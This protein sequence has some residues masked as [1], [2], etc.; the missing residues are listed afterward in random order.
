MGLSVIARDVSEQKR[1]EQALRRMSRYFA[2]SRDMVCTAGLD[3]Y[4]KQLNGMWT[5]TLGW[6]DAELRSRP[7]LTFVHPDD[8]QATL[9]ERAMLFDRGTTAAFVNRYA[10]KDGGWRWI[11]WNT[12]YAE[13]EQLIYAT[14]RDVTERRDA[15]SKSRFQPTCWTRWAKRLSRPTSPG[16]SSIGDPAPRR[17]TDGR[18]T[19]S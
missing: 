6:S 11:D 10:T 16:P 3:G 18:R 8:R 7:M 14:A 1:A 15:E 19:T 9:D 17:S 5:E 12:R 4:F 13:D 2:L